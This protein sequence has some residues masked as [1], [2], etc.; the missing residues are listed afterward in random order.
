MEILCNLVFEASDEELLC[1]TRNRK[2][3]KFL[4]LTVG[5]L[6]GNNLDFLI[7]LLLIDFL[8]VCRLLEFLDGVLDLR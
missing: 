1:S 8:F 6:L 3:L 2:T 4:Q 7:Q 5:V